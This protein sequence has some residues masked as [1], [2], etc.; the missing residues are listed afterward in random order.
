MSAVELTEAR[1]RYGFIHALADYCGDPQP[2]CQP[3]AAWPSGCTHDRH[4]RTGRLVA[5]QVVV[6]AL[7]STAH[8]RQPV[9][10]LSDKPDARDAT[11][12]YQP[13]GYT[14]DPAAVVLRPLATAIKDFAETVDRLPL[15]PI[16]RLRAQGVFVPLLVAVVVGWRPL[17]D[18]AAV[19]QLTPAWLLSRLRRLAA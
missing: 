6:A 5:P 19:Q 7:R 15:T 4:Y 8:S 3:N 14:I 17:L 2:S 18:E 1:L 11:E 16:N 13:S 10:L 9:V 12:V